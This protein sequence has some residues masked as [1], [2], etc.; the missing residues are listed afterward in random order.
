M[1]PYRGFVFLALYCLYN[2]HSSTS[3]VLYSMVCVPLK[4]AALFSLQLNSL[5]T[6]TTTSTEC[7]RHRVTKSKLGS[8]FSPFLQC[9]DQSHGLTRGAPWTKSL[10]PAITFF[11]L[12]L[13]PPP[14]KFRSYFWSV[15]RD[16]MWYLGEKWDGPYAKQ[17]SSPYT[18]S[19]VCNHYSFTDQ[20][21]VTL[22]E[23]SYF[24]FFWGGFEGSV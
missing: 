21:L 10:A 11:F 14:V 17:V 22:L 18:N 23:A 13:G 15:L 6:V 24:I 2:E 3:S 1:W 8:W 7:E 12:V 4:Q 5:S 19:L 9:Q 16:H 20:L